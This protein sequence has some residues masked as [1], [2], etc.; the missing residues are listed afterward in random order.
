M[1]QLIVRDL[2]DHLVQLLKERA[3]SRGHSAEE[4][5]RQ[6]LRAALQRRGLAEYLQSIPDVADDADFERQPDLPRS[7]DL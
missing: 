6:I 5:H 1:A 7:V 4:E 2:D 3:A